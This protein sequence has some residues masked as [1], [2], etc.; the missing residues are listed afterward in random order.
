M[1][2]RTA[3]ASTATKPLRNA[4][5][6]WCSV[7]GVRRERLPHAGALDQ[8]EARGRLDVRTPNPGSPSRLSA[9]VSARQGILSG[10]VPLPNGFFRGSPERSGD[11]FE[12]GKAAEEGPREH[13]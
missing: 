9:I 5:P 1:D 6:L 4:N 13:G 2:T 8:R 10:F 3:A 12:A 7:P 11:V